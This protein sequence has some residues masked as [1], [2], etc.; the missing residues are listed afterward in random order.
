MMTASMDKTTSW[1]LEKTG[2]TCKAVRQVTLVVSS[3]DTEAG[4]LSSRSSVGAVDP[5][6]PSVDNTSEEG[7]IRL[8]AIVSADRARVIVDAMLGSNDTDTAAL[9]PTL[10]ALVDREVESAETHGKLFEHLTSIVERILIGRVYETYQG[11][12]TRAAEHLGINRNTLH[13]KLCKYNFPLDTQ[14]FESVEPDPETI[15]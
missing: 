15:S 2:S 14:Q 6:E 13:K 3:V 1:T 4:S 10:E 11:V 8:E 5:S 7:P 12:Q 9:E